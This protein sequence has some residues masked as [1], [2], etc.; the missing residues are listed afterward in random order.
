MAER[1]TYPTK[2]NNPTDADS[3][4][5]FHATEANEIKEVVENH[6]DEIEA[7]QSQLLN[8]TNPYYG[9]YTSLSLL[10]AAHPTGEANAWAIIDQ[11]TGI[12]PKIAYWNTTGSTWEIATASDEKI[13]IANEAALPNPGVED[14]WYITLDKF[15]LFIWKNSQWE[16][17]GP[18][19]TGTISPQVTKQQI[20]INA[21]TTT[22]NIASK[23][24]VIFLFREGK[25]QIEHPQGDFTYNSSTGD[26][27]LFRAAEVDDFFEWVGFSANMMLK[28][29]VYATAN[30]QTDFNIGGNPNLI[31]V[32][33]EGH[34]LIENY[35]YTRTYFST[36][37]K[38]VIIRQDIVNN[39]TTG[40][41]FEIITN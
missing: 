2:T 22:L 20:N 24:A 34:R 11:G 13:Y 27:T 12:T 19:T 17:I 37:N 4:R 29:Q 40:D 28:Q 16:E 25:W 41:L 10:E 32:Y 33:H 30:N 15:Q 35:H 9:I 26:I 31:E 14:K 6:A 7:I 23:P 18:K 1:L 21:T 39:I 38:I 8:S 3:I 5:K 36:N